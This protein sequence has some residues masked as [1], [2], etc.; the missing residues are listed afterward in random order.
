MVPRAIGGVVGPNLKVYGTTN[1]RVVSKFQ[2][3]FDS[4]TITISSKVDASVIPLHLGTHLQRTVYGIGE[5]AAA[6][7]KSGK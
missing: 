7:I 1:V 5:K 4:Q 2:V 3:Y 6:I